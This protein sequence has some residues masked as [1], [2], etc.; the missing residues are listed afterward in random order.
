M[1]DIKYFKNKEAYRQYYSDYRARNREKI[2]AYRNLYDKSKRRDDKLF[3]A[4]QKTLR[5]SQGINEIWLEPDN[6]PEALRRNRY[7]K[8]FGS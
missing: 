8:T 7:W 6:N 4:E 1:P 3:L 2:R 5:Y